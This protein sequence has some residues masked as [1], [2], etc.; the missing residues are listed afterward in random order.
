M[1]PRRLQTPL[2]G[3]WEKGIGKERVEAGSAADSLPVQDGLSLPPGKTYLAQ[4]ILAERL[5]HLVSG[6]C[7]TWAACAR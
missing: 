7:K 6:N 3:K 5:T 2:L 4:N 1:V